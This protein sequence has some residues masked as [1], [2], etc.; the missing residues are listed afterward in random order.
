LT[1]DDYEFN[2][3]TPAFFIQGP[4]LFARFVFLSVLAIALIITDSRLQYLKAFRAQVEAYLHPLS[5]MANAPMQLFG[6][7]DSY[8]KSHQELLEEN[9]TLRNKLL[10]ANVDVQ[11]VKILQRENDQ[12]RDLSKLAS[13]H[14]QKQ[15][16]AEILHATSNQ[17]VREVVINRGRAHKVQLGAAVIDANG[18]VGQVT[19]LYPQTSLVTL[20]T[21]PSMEIPVM[22]ARNG[23]RAIAFGR[24]RNNLLEIP[25]LPAN[26]DI[27]VGDQLV[28]SG[29]D[30]V[31]PAGFAIGRVETIILEPGAGYIR[32]QCNV[33]GGVDFNRHV[34]V[35]NPMSPSAILADQQASAAQKSTQ[36]D[37]STTAQP[38]ANPLPYQSQ[39][40]IRVSN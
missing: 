35:V 23:L 7:A 22:V 14:Q 24:G 8:L 13:R 16:L 37:A 17:S 27:K 26:I 34:M 5:L 33:A 11:S 20:I 4:S 32:I 25:F 40:V 30:Y 21:N 9:K 2:Q 36:Q 10:K 29:I 19:R 1:R 28:T 3:A 38:T 31:Y 39:G 12:L 6:K 15:I 18:V